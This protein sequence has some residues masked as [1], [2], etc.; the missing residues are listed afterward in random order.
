MQKCE[1]SGVRLEFFTFF[2]KKV[3]NSSLTPDTSKQTK[4][5]RNLTEKQ[6]CD[7]LF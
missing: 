1:C 5:Y 4:E 7:T 3:K 6:F 2:I